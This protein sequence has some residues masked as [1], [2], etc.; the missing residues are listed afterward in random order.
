[1]IPNAVRYIL[2]NIMRVLLATVRTY[3]PVYAPTYAP[4]YHTYP[5]LQKNIYNCVRGMYNP[6]DLQLL[7][8]YQGLSDRVD[9]L[10]THDFAFKCFEY[11]NLRLL[12]YIHARQIDTEY[13]ENWPIY[14]AMYG[15]IDALKWIVEQGFD[16]GV[17]KR[18]ITLAAVKT[19]NLGILKYLQGISWLS[20][21]DYWR[22]PTRATE[23]KNAKILEWVQPLI[24]YDV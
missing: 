21:S 13:I 18:Y 19:N 4:T 15:N 23:Y 5:T 11:N 3:A 24:G 8:R 22:I 12:K 20:L 2:Q 1:M 16:L 9:T 17:K 14:A 7:D 6:L 10:D